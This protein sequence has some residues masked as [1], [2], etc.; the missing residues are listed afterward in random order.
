MDTTESRSFAARLADLLR[1]EQHAMA[2]FLV[3]LAEFDRQRAWV[4]LGYSGLFPFLHQKLGLSKSASFFRKT[5]AELIQRY[6][7][8]V[9]PLR[10]GRL[11]L[12]TMASVA[13]VIAPANRAEVL[14]RFFRRSALE[15]KAIVAELAPVPNPPTRT[16][17]TV[18]PVR[19]LPPAP[20]LMSVTDGAR[21]SH[22]EPGLDESTKEA[23]EP[24]ILQP[25]PSLRV[26][27][28]TPT[29][30]RIHVS[31]SPAF[32]TKLEDA[33]L[34]LSHSMPGADAEAILSAGLDLLLARDA[35]RKGLVA[36][37]RPA[38]ASE[39]EAGA[40]YVPMAAR[41]EVWTRDQ[42]ICQWPLDGGGVCGSRLDTDLVQRN[43]RCRG[44]KPIPSE[45]RVLCHMHNKLA[46]HLALGGELMNKYC[47]DP[48]QP[49]LAGLP[50]DASG[51]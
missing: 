42:S 1:N 34:A 49:L 8:I 37:P 27:P 26:E 15:A 4:A 20:A 44:A 39:A 47:R 32:V 31:V 18:T 11:C 29:V 24:L 33:R 19:A 3:A 46:A 48:R 23:A 10:D 16:V 7:E 12:S 6:P 45:L 38:P 21:G 13:K 51:G 22:G 9:E 25:S 50:G 43:L 36:K 14:P 40:V 28:L 5:A 35:K 17:V 2:D 41:R 30:T